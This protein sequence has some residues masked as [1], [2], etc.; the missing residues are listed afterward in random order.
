MSRRARLGVVLIPL[1]AF[2]ALGATP[3]RAQ[4]P[5][6]SAPADVIGEPLVID[7]PPPATATTPTPTTAA[8]PA[9]VVRPTQVLGVQ[10]RRAAPLAA[11]GIDPFG[12]MLLGVGLLALGNLL[13]VASTRR[14]TSVPS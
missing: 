3:A 5:P 12:L 10:I 11:T 7:R 1:L 4:T 8:A 2:F 13:V 6:T 9:P 14:R